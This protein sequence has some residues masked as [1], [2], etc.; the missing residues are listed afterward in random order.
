MV[1][2]CVR[3][4]AVS[5]CFWVDPRY[6]H[7]LHTSEHGACVLAGHGVYYISGAYS[8]DKY[9]RL[10]YD[11]PWFEDEQLS[12]HEMNLA[13]TYM[14]R[15]FKGIEEPIILSHTCPKKYMPVDS[16]L[17]GIDQSTVDNTMEEW[18]D[19]IEETS[20]YDRWYCGHY[21]VDRTQAD[22]KL[23]LMYHDI[24]MLEQVDELPY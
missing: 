17:P 3:N 14:N 8:V 9:Y 16:F 21:H 10:A 24:V 5:G 15:I 7:L 18:L 20:P 19:R 23:R 6:P 13:E 2:E 1:E 4:K 22:G 11:L 12:V